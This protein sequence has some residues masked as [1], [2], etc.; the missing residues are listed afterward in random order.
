DAAITELTRCIKELGFNGTMV[1]GFSQVGDLNTVVYLDDPRYLSFWEQLEQL[2]VP[3]YLHPRDP[4]P[5]REPVYDR[6]P[7]FM[8]SAC[9]SMQSLMSALI[10]SSAPSVTRTQR[11]SKPAHG[12][13]N[14]TA[15]RE[16]A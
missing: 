13:T 7:W 3:L 10:E 11:R 5:S 2:D 12:S 16:T 15:P 6:H 1:N 4:L 9:P 8:G 14:A